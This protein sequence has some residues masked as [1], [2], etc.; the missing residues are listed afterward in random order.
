MRA[1]IL[2]MIVFGIA[3]CSS[4]DVNDENNRIIQQ[5][6]ICVESGMDYQIGTNG[7]TG[8]RDAYCIKPGEK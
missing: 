6:K 5:K 3:G 7:L 2:V 4:R 1:C 8:D